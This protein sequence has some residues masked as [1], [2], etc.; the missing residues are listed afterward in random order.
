[1]EFLFFD[2]TFHFAG[3]RASNDSCTS[4]LV[5]TFGWVWKETA[6]PFDYVYFHFPCWYVILSA[7]LSSSLFILYLYSLP[8]SLDSKSVSRMFDNMACFLVLQK[9]PF[10]IL[11]VLLIICSPFFDA[12]LLAINKSRTFIYVY[13]ALRCLS[14]I[15]SLRS[16]FCIAIAYAVRYYSNCHL[17]TIDDVDY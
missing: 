15:L 8:S 17:K 4:T 3:C 1:M 5:W 16:V 12:V 6:S 7:S 10:T 13:F 11:I 9:L 2:I 14:Y